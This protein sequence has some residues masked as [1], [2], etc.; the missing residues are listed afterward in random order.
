M[1]EKRKYHK[2]F[3]NLI[4]LIKMHH[5]HD[6]NQ[7]IMLL[8]RNW[9]IYIVLGFL[10]LAK[11]SFCYI[12]WI[13]IHSKFPR[14][15]CYQPVKYSQLRLQQK[16]SSKLFNLQE[17]NNFENTS[18]GSFTSIDYPIKTKNIISKLTSNIQLALQNQLSRIEIEMPPGTNYGVEVKSKQSQLLDRESKSDLIRNSNREVARLL[19]EMFVSISSSTT[20]LF[21]TEDEAFKARNLW[22]GLFRGKVLSIDTPDAKGYGKLRSRRFT[23]E[24]QEQALL[25]SSDGIYIPENSDLLII[26]G[27][28]LKDLKKIKLISQKLTPATLIIL[29]NA[30]IGAMALESDSSNKSLGQWFQDTYY[31][32]FNYAP[33]IISNNIATKN[34]LLLFHEYSSRLWS[35]AKLEG[36]TNNM[37]GMNFGNTNR[38]ITIYQSKDRPNSKTLENVIEKL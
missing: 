12:P 37:L 13:Q 4:V 38:F 28:R 3:T 15:Y 24:E 2:F 30:R 8:Q 35:L 16:T 5:K 6:N 11:T 1:L 33:P 17:Q 7:G 19:T 23:I 14:I 9:N 18:Q 36:N 25:Q 29:L 26:V 31:N 20:V 34:E 21:P 22:G 32:V 27:P 10:L